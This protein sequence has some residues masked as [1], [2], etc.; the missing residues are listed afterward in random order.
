MQKRY[1]GKI[2]LVTSKKTPG[3]N[4]GNVTTKMKAKYLKYNKRKLYWLFTIEGLGMTL[5]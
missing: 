1:T 2:R 5:C 3:V 4:D